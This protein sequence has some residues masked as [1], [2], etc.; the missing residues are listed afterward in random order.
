MGIRLVYLLGMYLPV[1]SCWI[2][3]ISIYFSTVSESAWVVC[4]REKR[5]PYYKISCKQVSIHIQVPK[6]C[7]S[8]VG[9]G[10]VLRPR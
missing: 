4:K 8:K 7:V 1:M 2:R 3:K 6:S 9:R 10:A 5:G